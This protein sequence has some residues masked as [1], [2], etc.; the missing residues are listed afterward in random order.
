MLVHLHFSAQIW[1]GQVRG[2]L[3]QLM[4]EGRSNVFCC[5]NL[6][7]THQ[8]LYSKLADNYPLTNTL[9]TRDG[10]V[11][12]TDPQWVW[13]QFWRIMSDHGSKTIKD[14][15]LSIV[16]INQITN[17]R[18]TTSLLVLSQKKKPQRFFR[19]FE[20]PRINTLSFIFSKNLKGWFFKN[21]NNHILVQTNVGWLLSLD[22]GIDELP[23]DY[24]F[25]ITS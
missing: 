3:F 2:I 23:V 5:S 9:Q 13:A 1:F 16:D 18:T 4:I 11:T 21:S 24:F 7:L 19:V 20:I 6:P 25:L 12:G 15:W 10:Q 8:E 17:H 22:P 14:S